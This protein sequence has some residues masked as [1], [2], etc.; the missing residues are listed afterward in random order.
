MLHDRFT[1]GLCCMAMHKEPV[2]TFLDSFVKQ[3]EMHNEYLLLIYHCFDDIASVISDSSNAASI[4]G[5]I[6]YDALDAM[7]V[8]QSDEHQ[9]DIFKEICFNCFRTRNTCNFHRYTLR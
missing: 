4:F 3:I 5:A 2:K 8:Y 6:S 1:I 9:H 7:I